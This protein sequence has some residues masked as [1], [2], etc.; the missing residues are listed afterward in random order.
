MRMMRPIFVWTMTML[1]SDEDDE[2]AAGG[3]VLTTHM[4]IMRQIFVWM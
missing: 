2:A 1:F 3:T 4:R